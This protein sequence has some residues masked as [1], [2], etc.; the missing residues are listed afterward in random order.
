MRKTLLSTLVAGALAAGAFGVANAAVLTSV[1]FESGGGFTGTDGGTFPAPVS[2]SGF[3]TPLIGGTQYSSLNWGSPAPGSGAVI[4]QND[5]PLYGAHPG[6]GQDLSGTMAIDGARQDIGY[7]VHHNEVIAGGGFK[8]VTQIKYALDLYTD[9]TK[10]TSLYSGEYTFDLLFTETP[11]TS[12]CPAAPDNNPLGSICD[13]NFIYTMTGG[14]PLSFSYD[15]VNYNITLTGFWSE[16][17]PGGTLNPRYYS[18][19]EGEHHADFVSAAVSVPEPASL[20]LMG[21]GLA[22]LGVAARRRKQT[23]KA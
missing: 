1:Y 20:A 17:A 3:D 23:L 16:A 19:E 2:Y 6:T 5:P 12:P 11:N 21:L 9:A 10:A 22:A 18:A 8:G 14:S 15:G 7:L 4:N 13:D